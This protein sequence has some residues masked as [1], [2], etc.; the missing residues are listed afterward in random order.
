MAKPLKKTSLTNQELVQYY[1]QVLLP[2]VEEQGQSTLLNYHAMIIGVGGLGTHVAQQLSAAG[3]GH[4]HLFDDDHVE[5]SNLPRQ[6]L[7]SHKDLGQLKV[8]AAKQQLA[9][10]SGK[11]NIHAYCCKFSQT[12]MDDLLQTQLLLTQ[13][14]R[15]KRIVILDC[16][17]N[18][19]TRQT[20]NTWSINHSVPLISGAITAFNG[21]VMEVDLTKYPQQG[22]YHCI[23][24]EQ[25]VA[26][27]CADMGV[28]GPSV[29]LI[30]SMQA[31][32]AIQN[33]LSITQSE[34]KLHLFDGKTLSWRQLSRHRDPHCNQCSSPLI[35]NRGS[36][37]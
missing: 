5:A 21:Q 18:M 28:L 10:L 14:L 26:Q 20:V 29:A 23:F 36:L 11:D 27:N 8:D 3:I 25:E 9:R 7:Y 31:L 15:H 37:S 33:I 1:R 6:I 16:S 17:D 34:P 12:S 32:M 2:E 19:Q 30:A 22:C 13:A 35:Q 4:L 24:D